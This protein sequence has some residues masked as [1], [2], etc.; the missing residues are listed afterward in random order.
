M[1]QY[2]EM[3]R[4]MDKK[5][6]KISQDRQE[7]IAHLRIHHNVHDNANNRDDEDEETN[8][9]IVARLAREHQL[10]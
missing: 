2:I 10:Q 9:Q 4:S 7:I 5:Q 3:K 6:E 8:E 1:G